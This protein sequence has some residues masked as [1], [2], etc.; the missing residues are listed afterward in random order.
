MNSNKLRPCSYA[1]TTRLV[2][3]EPNLP[4]GSL[5]WIRQRSGTARTGIRYQVAAEEA[6]REDWSDRQREYWVD[7]D[8]L[9]PAPA[10][11]A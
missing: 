3:G 4:T 10:P 8:A 6:G 7:G 5:V 2:Y 11:K 9:E 1:R